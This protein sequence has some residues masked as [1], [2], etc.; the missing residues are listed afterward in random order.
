MKITKSRLKKIIREELKRVVEGAGAGDFSWQGEDTVDYE[1]GRPI[2]EDEDSITQD[3]MKGITKMIEFWATDEAGFAR[4]PGDWAKAKNKLRDLASGGPLPQNH[5]QFPGWT[6]KDFKKVIAAVDGRR[7]NAA[8]QEKKKKKKKKDDDFL[9]DVKSTGEWT[10]Y[11]IAQL[12]KKKAA[13]M[14]K[15]SRT[16]PEQKKVSQIQFAINAK[17]GD[18]K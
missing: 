14:K 8:L 17:E 10:D 2:Y 11:T 4:K 12:K 3:E 7:G 16:K 13:L 15:K 1:A 18:Y 5:A 9:Q 6:E